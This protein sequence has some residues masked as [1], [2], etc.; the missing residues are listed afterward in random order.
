MNEIYRGFDLLI[1]N[2]IKRN[3]IHPSW[4]IALRV[5]QMVNF[6]NKFAHKF[7]IIKGFELTIFFFKESQAT[8]YFTTEVE[9]LKFP[10]NVCQKGFVFHVSSE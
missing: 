8:A 10:Q 6:K 5:K 3:S 4:H 9:R 1:P 7:Q 2:L